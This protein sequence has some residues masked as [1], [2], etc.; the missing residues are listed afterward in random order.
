[1]SI[2]Q[3][4]PNP[5]GKSQ[6]PC[7]QD[8]S[9]CPEPC[10]CKIRVDD[11]CVDITSNFSC[12]GITKGM[13][14]EE[15]IG[16]INEQ[17]EAEDEAFN[18][19]L[20]NVGNGAEVYVGQNADDEHEFRTL[21]SSDESITITQEATEIDA[22]INQTWLLQFLQDNAC[23]IQSYLDAC[24]CT[25]YA[26]TVG[27]ITDTSFNITITNWDV[28]DVYDVFV[29]GVP[30]LTGVS[31]Q[32]TTV[33]GLSLN[34]SYEVYVRRNRGDLRCDSEA[35]DVLTTGQPPCLAYNFTVDNIDYTSFEI[36]ITNFVL[37]DTWNL[38]IDGTPVQTNIN[39]G[40]YIVTGLD[41]N[42][43]YDIDVIRHCA[44][45]GTAATDGDATTLNCEAYTFSLEGSTPD[46]LTITITNFVA[47]G[48]IPWQY[49]LDGGNTFLPAS[50]PFITTGSTTINGLPVGVYDVVVRK[51][52]DESADVKSDSDMQQWTIYDTCVTYAFDLID[53]TDE[54]FTIK[55]LNWVGADNWNVYLSTSP[56]TLPTAALTTV[57]GSDVYQVTGLTPNQQYYVIVERICASGGTLVSPE[58]DITTNSIA[59]E[60]CPEAYIQDFA[61][62]QSDVRYTALTLTM[63]NFIVGDNWTV[64]FNKDGAGWVPE[65]TVWTV[66]TAYFTLDPAASYQ[67]RVTRLTCNGGG[68]PT[69][70]AVHSFS[71]ACVSYALQEYNKTAN[72]IEI[73]LA[74][75]STGTWDLS[76]DNGATFPYTGL[77]GSFHTITN[78]AP[79][80][81]YNIVVRRTCGV[82]VNSFPLVVTTLP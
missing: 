37:G 12:L 22:V 79:N 59:E 39:T 76:I 10:G 9:N 35:Q 56:I 6:T 61:T 55:V 65:G 49:S 13:T 60:D 40:S 20:V 70:G 7:E 17:C 58:Q 62:G 68:S 42:T 77:S 15:A 43:L 33:T 66:P 51:V 82:S 47:G 64:E 28:N 24:V 34:T 80:T 57:T 23:T 41:P 67:L 75:Y 36:T 50:A 2:F 48:S 54:G 72:T 53:R 19:V 25:P 27:N 11:V 18:P 1:M 16:K 31:S 73:G 52:C 4:V 3:S 46:D 14:L 69:V 8:S 78:L 30:V 32:S 29:D 74:N 45:G 81:T 63:E 38:E 5:C 26:F 71:T 44:A 21:K